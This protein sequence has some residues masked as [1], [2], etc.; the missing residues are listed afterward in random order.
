[1]CQARTGAYQAHTGVYQVRTGVSQARTGMC[2]VRTSVCQARTDKRRSLRTG[3][4]RPIAP[5]SASDPSNLKPRVR[6][7][8][9]KPRSTSNRQRPT[10]NWNRFARIL[11]VWELE[12]GTWELTRLFFI[13]LRPHHPHHSL[14]GW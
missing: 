12:I 11:E 6:S 1:M 9:K 8:P 4:V 3:I 14:Y 7:V 13:S 10:S 2:Q 5:D